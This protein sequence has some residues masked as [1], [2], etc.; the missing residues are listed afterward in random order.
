M[1]NPIT[2]RCGQDCFLSCDGLVQI[3]RY[4]FGRNRKVGI[5]RQASYTVSIV[6]S[7]IVNSVYG[8]CKDSWIQTI[9]EHESDLSLFKCVWIEA[10][11]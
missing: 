1:F 3:L 4:M 9:P 5:V 11:P 8:I 7:Q 2:G 6:D 10:K